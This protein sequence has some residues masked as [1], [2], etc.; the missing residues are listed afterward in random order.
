ME[1]GASRG[2]RLSRKVLTWA[3]A[4]TLA[5]GGVPAQALGAELPEA[6]DARAETTSTDSLVAQ[7]SLGESGLSW[8]LD[9]A[10]QLTIEGAGT[11]DCAGSDFS[12]S[13]W[14]AYSDAI[15]SAVIEP[16][17]RPG[18]SLARLFYGC[19]GLRSVTFPDWDTSAVTDL[20]QMFSGCHSLTQVDLAS[21]DTSHVTAMEGLFAG[22]TALTSLDLS[23]W[24]TSSVTDLSQMFSGCSSLS[25]LDL[26]GWDTSAVTNMSSLFGG[27][28]RLASLRLGAGWDT[29]SV[30][31]MGVLF[32]GCSS[33]SALDLS[34]WNTSQV[35]NMGSLFGGCSALATLN[36]GDWDTANVTTL[37]G[38]FVGCSSLR[39]LDLSG[40]STNSAL[41]AGGV[42]AG[43][44]SLQSLRFGNGW[45]LPLEASSLPAHTTWYNGADEAMVV[46]WIPTAGTYTTT[47]PAPLPVQPAPSPSA[48]ATVVPSPSRPAVQKTSGVRLK[49]N[50]HGTV[51]LKKRGKTVRLKANLPVKWS[52]SDKRVAVVSKSGKVRAKRTGFARITAKAANGKTASVLIQVGKPV[53]VKSVTL[54]KGKKKLSRVAVVKLSK[55]GRAVRLAAKVR[56]TRAAAKKV[57]WRSSNRKVAIVSKSGK[58]VAKGKGTCKITATTVEGKK[59]T[60]KVRV[61]R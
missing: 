20:S 22:C 24:N 30:V 42:F 44:T 2:K 6:G 54:Y 27:C 5:V 12:P 59:A 47:R 43:C 51:K 61:L 40:W 15:E 26:T 50:R 25:A 1:Q 49:L 46:P 36:V 9:D 11:L 7:G 48:P 55:P 23:A 4:A 33:L 32:S 53:K 19:A 18:A 31:Y 10:G 41:S 57:T 38:L 39:S 29:S 34:G 56:P 28:S 35:V 37:G 60:V 17:V 58:V 21:W 52:S 8:A 14:S 13:P 16:G 3:V 45:T